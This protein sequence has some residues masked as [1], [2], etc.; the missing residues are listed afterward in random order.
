MNTTEAVL[1][2]TKSPVIKYSPKYCAVYSMY[3]FNSEFRVCN[4]YIHFVIVL[5]FSVMLYSKILENLRCRKSVFYTFNVMV[6][7]PDFIILNYSIFIH[8]RL[9]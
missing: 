8:E 2:D 1:L 5:K 6:N 3:S 4:K 7:C 9:P